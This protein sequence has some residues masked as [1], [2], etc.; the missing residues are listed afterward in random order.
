MKILLLLRTRRAARS[1]ETAIT[2]HAIRSEEFDPVK[3][4]RHVPDVYSAA[5]EKARIEALR[6]GHSVSEQP[7]SDGSIKLVIQVGGA[8]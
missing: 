3:R 6:R 8:S 5:V 4:N 2:E 7:L 1:T